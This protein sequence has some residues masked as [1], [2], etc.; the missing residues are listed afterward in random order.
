LISL[1]KIL[2]D[3]LVLFMHNSNMMKR[4]P[5]S[6]RN[7]ALYMLTNCVTGDRYIGI[8]VVKNGVQKSLKVR[9]QKHVRRALTENKGWALCQSICK[10]GADNFVIELVC[11]VRGRGLAHAIERDLIAQH[12]PELNQ[13]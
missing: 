9:W 4:K 10:T 1:K 3:I 12:K 11:K 6:D 2:V 8:T 7:H 5:R 13:Y